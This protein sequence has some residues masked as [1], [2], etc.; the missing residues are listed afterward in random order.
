MTNAYRFLR[1]VYRDDHMRPHGERRRIGRDLLYYARNR[2][3]QPLE[4]VLR[5]RY[6]EAEYP[7]VFIVGVPR[8]GT[9]LLYQLMARFLR[10]GYI[11]NRMA[12]YWMTPIAGA[13]LSGRIDRSQIELASRY[14]AGSTDMSPHEFSWF[15]QFYGYMT[16]HDHLDD[17][18]LSKIDWKSI[19][20][21]LSGLAEYAQAPLVLKSLNYVDYHISWLQRQI[22]RAKFVWIERDDIAASGSIL[23]VR[24]ARYGDASIWWSVRPRDFHEWAER[25]PE[26]QVAHQVRDIKGSIEEAFSGLDSST[27]F[28][29]SYESLVASP[30]RV[31]S[32]LS[33]FLGASIVDRDSLECLRLSQ[34]SVS[35]DSQLT[36][37][38]VNAL[39]ACR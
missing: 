8:S 19:T 23:G 28:R 25:P 30:A 26:E 15:W 17:R 4:C 32:E 12:G 5:R 36:K 39:E 27:A 9:T 2:S 37:R 13:M 3:L 18:A 29:T 31:V 7:I 22:P 10:V 33:E 20:A 6:R 1:H 21:S 11:T 16:E 35:A 38:I 24:E 14:G 34:S